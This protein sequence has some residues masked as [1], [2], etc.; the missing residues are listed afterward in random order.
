MDDPENEH[1]LYQ[2]GVSILKE[3]KT[4]PL[5]RNIKSL[6][7]NEEEFQ[8]YRFHNLVKIGA[9]IENNGLTKN[10]KA[11]MTGAFKYISINENQ[12]EI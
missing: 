8:K 2:L 5:L 10:N 4:S 3:K 7:N 6:F 9:I 12:H 11:A 1:L